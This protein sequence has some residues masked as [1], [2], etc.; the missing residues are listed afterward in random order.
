MFE[1]RNTLLGTITYP[2]FEG[3][4]QYMIFLFPRWDM[5]VSKTAEVVLYLLLVGGGNSNIVFM[6]SCIWGRFPIWQIFFQMGWNHQPVLFCSERCLMIYNQG[7]HLI[8]NFT[9][10]GM[11]W[12][13]RRFECGHTDVE[14]RSW[15]VQKVRIDVCIYIYI[16]ILYVYICNICIWLVGWIWW[17][18]LVSAERIWNA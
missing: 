18:E 4:F 15:R 17:W 9:T 2:L 10:S 5:L 16:H 8:S 11:T 13:S 12:N 7:C 14:E 3:I 1:I 6:F